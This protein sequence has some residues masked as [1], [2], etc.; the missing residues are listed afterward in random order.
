MRLTLEGKP[1]SVNQLYRG[2][3]FL[4]ERGRLMKEDYYYQ[5]RAQYKGPILQG[6]LAIQVHVHF[7]SG[8]T[9]DLDNAL[10]ASLDS[11]TG[12]LW[13]DDRQ[14][15]ELHAYKHQDKERPRIEVEVVQLGV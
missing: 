7:R 13:E 10:K 12:V 11:L 2:R 6:P 1:V 9:C 14:I 8:K 4:T 3:R 15:V 5:A